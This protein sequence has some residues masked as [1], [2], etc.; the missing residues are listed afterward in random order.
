[1]TIAGTRPADPAKPQYSDGHR[2]E[3][4][5]DAP[6]DIACLCDGSWLVT[7]Y[8]HGTIRRVTNDG[9]VSTLCGMPPSSSAVRILYPL[10]VL[11]TRG[12]C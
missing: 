11:L 2:L 4:Q 10:C 1:M 6:K 8:N 9:D 7:E 12:R 5:F 3:A